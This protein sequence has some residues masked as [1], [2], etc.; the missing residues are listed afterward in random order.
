MALFGGHISESDSHTFCF[1]GV[2]GSGMFLP[3]LIRGRKVVIKDSPI[4]WGGTRWRLGIHTLTPFYV[5]PDMLL[6]IL[7]RQIKLARR[8]R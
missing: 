2:V 6:L 7:I 1:L 5:N 8:L 4:P 3:P